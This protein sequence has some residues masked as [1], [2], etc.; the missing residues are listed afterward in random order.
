LCAPAYRQPGRSRA[1]VALVPR[2]YYC[3]GGKISPFVR[4]IT[5]ILALAKLQPPQR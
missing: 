1:T 2:S 4:E 5:P 3:L